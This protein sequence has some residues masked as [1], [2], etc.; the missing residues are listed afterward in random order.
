[1]EIGLVLR[2]ITL[3][4][5]VLTF[6]ISAYF[7]KI[8][9]DTGD[10]IDRREEGLFVLFL[11]MAFGL[12]LLAT[13]VLNI[14]YPRALL[15]SKIDLP[16][17]IQIIGTFLAVLCVPLILWVFRS[18]GNNISETLLTK[19]DHD[20]VTRGPY[21]WVRHP[22]YSSTLFLLFSISIIF[23]DWIIFIYTISGMIVFRYLV[24]PAEEDKLIAAFGEEYEKYQSRTGAL[25]PRLR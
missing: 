2:I 20:L 10:V 11:R 3:L 7:R 12:P 22:L 16:L 18:I 25:L 6:S 9:R 5:L 24:I 17:F 19:R 8:A 21:R 1:M 23:G 14:F 15:W 13:V 4:I